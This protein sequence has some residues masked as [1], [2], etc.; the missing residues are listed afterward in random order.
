MPGP[1]SDQRH[2]ID[3]NGRQDLDNRG[4][5]GDEQNKPLP[6]YQKNQHRRNNHLNQR[7]I[8]RMKISGKI[9]TTI[10]TLLTKKRHANFQN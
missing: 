4:F 1:V 10:A 8:E 6:H 7:G 3:I 2:E 5:E 9:S